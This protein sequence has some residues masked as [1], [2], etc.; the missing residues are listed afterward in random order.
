MPEHDGVHP[1]SGSL[2]ARRSL[3]ARLRALRRPRR[4]TVFALVAASVLLVVATLTVRT[5][6]RYRTA[7]VM[8]VPVREFTNA[9]YPE[10]P[11][12]RS[13]DFG[14]YNGRDL[15]L[16]QR[17][18]THFNFVFEPRHPHIARV[19]FRNVDVSLMTPSL[20][21]WARSDPGLVRIALT[22]RQWNRQ[23]VS[24]DRSVVEVE[25]GDGLEAGKFARGELS[26]EL[27]KNCLNAGL[28]ELLLF[29]KDAKSGR[30]QLYYQ[31]WFTFPLGHYRRLFERNTG[32]AYVR[33]WYYL[34]HWF[35]PA[36]TPLPLEKLRRVRRER[37]VT[38]EFLGDER[39]LAAGEQSRKQRT[40]MADN[41]VHWADFFD[42]RN[43]RF[44]TF[45]PPG[46]YSVRHPWK[47]EYW[48]MERLE[49]AIL[50]DVVSP[51]SDTPLQ[52]LE[53]VFSSRRP[54]IMRFVVSGFDLAKLP[55]LVPQDY[56]RTMAATAGKDQALAYMPMGIGTPPFFQEYSQLQQSPPEKG[57]YFCL[58]LDENGRW[59][60]HHEVGIDGPVLHCDDTEDGVLHVYLL[61]Y[62]R[63]SLIG[64]WRIEG[65]SSSNAHGVAKK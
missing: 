31:D 56:A 13:P 22:D 24:F 2:G 44:A 62:E 28:W 25:E 34:E 15:R 5:L 63:H 50:R 52:E 20:P 64:H 54:G 12:D 3:A 4:R 59:I 43:V 48:R 65:L 39:V 38:A 61:S 30:K 19:T 8:D 47:N 6:L 21:E 27:A 51:A 9:E 57:P 53:L 1:E 18:E 55:R 45:L 49:K 60:N 36:G 40:T 46:R 26:A 7:A 14:R 23:Q 29:F 16:V 33:H 32:L 41:V 10:D 17:D 11:A 58:T 42:G 35:D 37:V